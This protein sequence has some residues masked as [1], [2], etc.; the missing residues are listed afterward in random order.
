MG[1]LLICMLGYIAY[2]N[3]APQAR[4]HMNADADSIEAPVDETTLGEKDAATAVVERVDDVIQE[5]VEATEELAVYTLLDVAAHSSEES[6]WTAVD[7][8]VYDLTPALDSHPG[9][10]A[11]IMK[12]CGIDGTSAFTGKHGESDKAKAAIATRYIGVLSDVQ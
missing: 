6:C 1:V 8:K 10:K 2:V 11:N 7:G 3:V 4:E 9:G 12:I 5:G